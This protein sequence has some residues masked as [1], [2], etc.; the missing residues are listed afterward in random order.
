MSKESVKMAI[1]EELARREYIDYC[2][3]TMPDWI[4]GKHIDMMADTLDY[5]L[6]SDERILTLS[7]PPQ[8]GKSMF[9]TETLASYEMMKHGKR[10]ILAS[11]GDDLARRFGRRNRMKIKEFG[12]IFDAEIKKDSDTDI[13]LGNGGTMISRGIMAGITG[14]PADLIIIDDPIKNR[15]EA[16]SETYRNRLWEEFLNSLYT[17]LSADGK[18]ILIMTRWHEDDLA[19]KLHANMNCAKLNIQLEAEEGDILGR[20]PG[21]AL[22]P[23]IGKDKAW[24]AKF[25]KV[26]KNKK[27]SRAWNAL[28]QGRPTSAEGNI[29]KRESWQYYTKRKAFVDTLPTLIL[30]VDAT[31]KGEEDNDK[32]S[33]QV[34][35]K[36]KA[37]CYLVDNVTD[38]MT[39]TA[40]IKAIRTLLLK[41]PTI[42]GK[43]IEEKANGAAIIDVLNRSIGGF[44]PVKADRSTG[45]K[46]ARVKAIEP[47]ITAENVYLP[48]DEPWVHDF[49]EECSAFPSGAHDDQVD[50]MSQALNKLYFFMSEIQKH[51][52]STDL[53]FFM[54]DEI[55]EV[56]FDDMSVDDSF[57]NY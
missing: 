19:G 27:G 35:G 40:T 6:N 44:I 17:R 31:F 37:F 13:E 14:Q 38:N 4:V 21:D 33:L 45:G 49:V 42:N 28:M 48:N 16:D 30:S 54:D 47:Y 55:D 56:L 22:F 25:K 41:Y 2:K 53:S 10:V 7:V 46:I 24:L 52:A 20:Q 12:Y 57:I 50:A 1:R 39:F 18:I 32:V 29:L 11:Y 34:W 5:F 8:H 36:K 23:E 51:D 9:I 3:L 43:Y 15:Q 26:Y